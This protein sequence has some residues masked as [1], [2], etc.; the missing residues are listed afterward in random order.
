MHRGV[1][2]GFL[3]FSA[4][5]L[6]L[7]ELLSIFSALRPAPLAAAWLAVLAVAAF[8]LRPARGRPVWPGVIDGALIAAVGAI[9]AIVL[10]IALK[11]PPNSTDAMAYHMPRVIYWTQAAGVAFFPTPYLNQIM[12]QPMAEYIVL[13]TYVL[14]GGDRLGNLPQLLGFVFSVVGVSLVAQQFGAARRG[15]ILAALFCATLPNGILQASGAKNDYLMTAYLVAMVYFVKEQSRSAGWWAGLALGVALLTKATAYLF[16]PPLLLALWAPRRWPI[17]AAAALL[18]NAPH[19]ARNI[20]LSGSPLGYDSAQADGRF[21]WHNDRFGWR[22]TASNL[23]RHLGDQLGAR[24]EQWNRGVYGTVVA[25]HHLIGVD[26]NDPATT[27]PGAHYAPPRNANH[28]TNA[29][30]RWHLLLLALALPLLALRWRTPLARYFVALLGGLLIFAFYLKWQPFVARLL[31]PL[32]VLGSPAAG[33]LLDL[34]PVWLQ[35]AVCLFLLNNTRP[36]LFE[37]WIR[38]LNGPRSI[39]RVAR[40]DL[41]FADM[42]LWNNKASYLDTVD[43]VARNGC[44][45]VGIDINRLTLEYPL[46]VLLKQRLPGVEFVHTGVSNSSKKY[47]RPSQPCAVVCL[48]CAGDGEAREYYRSL[49]EPRLIGKFLLYLPGPRP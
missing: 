22:E 12:L 7:T 15:Q 11:S 3:A 9:A 41:Y 1:L 17:M 29:N 46:Q 27:W 35:L 49:G 18:V 32:F 21:R 2:A 42:T 48:D 45:L 44:R 47:E 38:P 39:L 14:T 31:L 26:P 13:H 20:D 5:L 40:D 25:M 36:Y 6:A 30:N 19:Y 37:N 24:S 33:V 10:F 23:L 28:E 43:A 4:I 34:A 8:R 16:A